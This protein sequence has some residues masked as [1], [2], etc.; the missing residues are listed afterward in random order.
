MSK[1]LW[2][3][4]V[5]AACLSASCRWGGEEI[6]RLPPPGTHAPTTTRPPDVPL[7]LNLGS[8]NYYAPTLPFLDV[9][10][11]ADDAQTTNAA[12]GG[13]WDSGDRKSTRLNSSHLGIS[14]AVFCLKK[15]K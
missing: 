13:Q 12:G 6:D 14:Y 9:M 3:A 7:G 1:R 15:K 10:K 11:N 4:C 2:L 5:V 8:L